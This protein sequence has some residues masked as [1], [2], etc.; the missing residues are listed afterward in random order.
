MNADDIQR[1]LATPA[2]AALS[3][4]LAESPLYPD[5][6]IGGLVA[7]ALIGRGAT[8]DVWRV[9]DEASGQDL[10]L[11]LFRPRTDV[12]PERARARFCAEARLLSAFRHPNLMR[13]FASGTF[14]GEPYF[15]MELLRPLPER[16][17]P[18]SI[19][20]LGRDLCRA[21]A[22]LHEH[23]I[24]HRDLK[25]DNVLVAPDGRYVLADLGIAHF[26]DDALSGFVHGLGR[27]NPTLA[28]G[29]DRALGTPGFAAP[30]Q[31][32]GKVVSPAADIHALGALFA[33]LFDGRPPFAWRILIRDMASSLPMLRCHSLATVRRALAV[34][35][36][37][38]Y[39][40]ILTAVAVCLA[41]AAGIFAYC[42]PKW[43][44]LPINADRRC[45]IQ[46]DG[47]ERKLNGTW[48]ALPKEG[49]Y[50]Y[51]R[52]LVSNPG[53]EYYLK[54][55]EARFSFGYFRRPFAVAGPGT[56]K[57]P[58]IVGHDV[59]LV[60]N[61]TLI[62]SGT[63]PTNDFTRALLKRDYPTD[64]SGHSILLPTYHV[65]V[66]SRI[67]FTENSSYPQELIDYPKDS[68][69]TL[70]FRLDPFP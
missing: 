14:R 38:S 18:R 23:G 21:L 57:V 61:A 19:A 41:L 4:D 39:A 17:S 16:L 55:G 11:K 24:V 59:Y 36:A 56:L 8:G 64:S 67:I 49:H 53:P 60:S 46:M 58:F 42:R 69:R 6:R 7:V 27:G 10:A 2:A 48:V 29:V 50:T 44:E 34:L 15:T 47:M 45:V 9:H 37:L 40:R 68:I 52:P 32:Q 65:E 43:E 31:M 25:P 12:P 1:Y 3:A 63:L 28:D 13:V 62:T 54:P 66:G 5:D 70:S 33:A 35:G 20:A 51:P 30:E 22:Y 26:S